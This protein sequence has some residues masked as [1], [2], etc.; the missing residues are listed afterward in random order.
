[1]E[2]AGDR[3]DVGLLTAVRDALGVELKDTDAVWDGVRDGDRVALGEGEAE[4]HVR[5]STCMGGG[6]RGREGEGGGGRGREGDTCQA[7]ASSGGTHA[8]TPGSKAIPTEGISPAPQHPSPPSPHPINQSLYPA[9][10][11]HITKLRELTWMLSSPSEGYTT[12]G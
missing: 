2:G 1:L 12:S 11:P 3:V 10:P 5:T 8:H 7:R 6:G 4:G 9:A